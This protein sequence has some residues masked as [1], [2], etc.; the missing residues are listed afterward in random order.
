M[1]AQCMCW[2]LVEGRGADKN[3][4]V[5]WDSKVAHLSISLVLADFSEIM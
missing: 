4:H 1:R 2:V 3:R 5:C